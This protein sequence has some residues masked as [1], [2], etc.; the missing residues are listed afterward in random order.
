M[1]VKAR[2]IGQAIIAASDVA[3]QTLAIDSETLVLSTETGTIKFDLRRILTALSPVPATV[4]DVTE[5]LPE[6]RPLVR[7]RPDDGEPMWQQINAM[8]ERHH[9]NPPF[10][11]LRDELV[12]RLDWA[13]YGEA[14]EAMLPASPAS[15]SIQGEG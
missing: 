12:T 5:A 1:A 10:W 7:L 9:E 8:F 14:L 11:R 15:S 4:P 6:K 2:D 13:R 3:D